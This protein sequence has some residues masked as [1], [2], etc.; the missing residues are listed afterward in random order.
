MNRAKLVMLA[1]TSLC[2]SFGAAYA[3]DMPV[4]APVAPVVVSD[5]W[6]GIYAGGNIG[7]SFGRTDDATNVAP[8]FTNNLGNFG[9]FSFPG[10]TAA[11]SSNVNGVIGGG[12]IG[13]IGRIAP[14]WLAGVEADIQW[15][16][17]RGTAHGAFGGTT[18]D[19]TTDDCSFANAHDITKKLNYFGT[20]RGRT[21][22]E[23]NGVWIYG[24]GGL[25]YGEVSLSGNNTLSLFDNSTTPRT[26]V[27]TISTPLNRSEFQVGWTAGIG[28]EGLIALTNWRWKVEYLHIDLGSSG[29]GLFGGGFSQ[30]L[31][32]GT[33]FTD[34]IVRIGFNYKFDCDRLIVAKY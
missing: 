31:V 2:L 32:N 9:S 16:G 7:Y 12:Q 11:T 23:W 5:P 30:V 15:S 1:S 18:S 33:R 21:G 17:Q 29:G 13:F 28:V 19:C 6:V 26:L 25:A 8:F 3:A 34:E 24:T 20:L 22:G 4:K 10:G 27:G 14:H